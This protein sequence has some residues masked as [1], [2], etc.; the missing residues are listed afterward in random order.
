MPRDERP[1]CTVNFAGGLRPPMGFV[2]AEGVIRL[3]DVLELRAR[4]G[5]DPQNRLLLEELRLVGAARRAQLAFEYVLYTP[6]LFSGEPCKQLVEGP[7]LGAGKSV[8]TRPLTRYR[9]V[10]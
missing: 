5:I 4:K 6:E 9:G 3:A 7:Q 8:E 10:T 2:C 1:R